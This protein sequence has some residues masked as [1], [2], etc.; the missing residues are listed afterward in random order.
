VDTEEVRQLD[1]LADERED[2][3]GRQ[4]ARVVGD[5]DAE[6]L[7]QLVPADLCQVVALRIEEEGT[8]EV[9]RVVERRWLA[10]ALL[11]EHLDQGLLLA[12]GGILVERVD[13][14]ARVVEELEDRLVVRGVDLE[15][16]RG[17]LGRE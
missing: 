6:A 1:E 14:V 13:D 9:P 11:L 4:Y 8:Q 17:V 2:V 3:L 5:V 10:G 15:A 7:V 16:G 12:G